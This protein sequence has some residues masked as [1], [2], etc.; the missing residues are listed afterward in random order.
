MKNYNVFLGSDSFQLKNK[1]TREEVENH[2]KIKAIL[3]EIKKLVTLS[4]NTPIENFKFDFYEKYE[5]SFKKNFAFIFWSIDYDNRNKLYLMCG[6][7]EENEMYEFEIDCALS[8][9]KKDEW[10]IKIKND[11][12]NN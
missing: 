4:E 5:D 1:K 8:L 6:V 7:Q 2:P 12:N 3:D 10:K 11:I 9:L